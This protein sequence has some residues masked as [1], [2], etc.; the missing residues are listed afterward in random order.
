MFVSQTDY[1]DRLFD[2]L[3]KENMY[4]SLEM[5]VDYPKYYKTTYNFLVLDL[6][7]VYFN[8]FSPWKHFLFYKTT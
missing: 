6:F 3:A 4:Y 8:N 7:Y 1:A 2:E 5:P